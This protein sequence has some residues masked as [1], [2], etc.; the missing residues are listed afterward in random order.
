MRHLERPVDDP[1]VRCP[2]ISLATATLGWRPEVSLDD[3]LRRTARWFA[4]TMDLP[5]GEGP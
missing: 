1:S 3:G 5:L 4:D 2:D